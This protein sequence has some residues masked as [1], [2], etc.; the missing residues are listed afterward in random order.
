MNN[1]T[2]KGIVLAGGSG[3]RLYPLT[4][5]TSKQLLPIYDKPMVYYP[6]SVLMLSG[7]REILIISTP[8]DIGGFQRLLSDGSELGLSISYAVQ[9]EP[10][11][12]AQAFLIGREFVASEP[13]TMILGDNLFYGHGLQAHLQSA[14]ARPHGA[15]V[16]SYEVHDPERYGIVELNADG[17]P[18]AIVEKP[19]E[20]RSNLAVTG[21][22]FYDNDVLD[23]AA[24]LRPSARGEL[25][26]TAVNDVYLRRGQLNV[27][28][29]S[30]GFAWLDTGTEASLIDA[31]NFVKTIEDR[32]GLKIACIE[33]IAFRQGFIDRGQLQAIAQRLKNPYGEYLDRL[34][35]TV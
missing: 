4:R 8:H 14:A 11:G 30:R 31:G 21:L 6:L 33:E 18:V 34:T 16:F 25:E 10:G 19:R 22:Y 15:T 20:P 35:A 26:I 32:Q 28:H 3:S 12:L 13:V 29:L 5:A 1:S 17:H 24:G 2:R 23:I 9:P 7:I 27:E